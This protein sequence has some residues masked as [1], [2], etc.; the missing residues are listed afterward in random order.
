MTPPHNNT[1]SVLLKLL[2]T[3]ATL[4]SVII[5]TP[6]TYIAALLGIYWAKRPTLSRFLVFFSA[7]LLADL[8]LPNHLGIYPLLFSINAAIAWTVISHTKRVRISALAILIILTVIIEE[9]LGNLLVQIA[10]KQP[11]E[12]T[13]YLSYG[14]TII[15]L[16]MFTLQSVY[17]RYRT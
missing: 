10:L 14:R 13:L 17:E 4:I 15:T 6:Y 11:I 2:K 9:V 16:L 12:L 3:L 7:L 8:T 5:L 1:N